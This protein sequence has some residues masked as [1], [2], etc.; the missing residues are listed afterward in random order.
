MM[1]LIMKLV[2]LFRDDDSSTGGGI[3]IGT[4]TWPDGATILWPDGSYMKWPS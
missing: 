1:K 3:P 4:M 2:V